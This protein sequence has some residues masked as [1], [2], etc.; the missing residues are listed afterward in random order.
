MNRPPGTAL[1]NI[2]VVQAE[3][4]FDPN[5]TF[6]LVAPVSNSLFYSVQGPRPNDPKV[7]FR[8]P[9][10]ANVIGGGSWVS[11][12]EVLTGM[13]SRLFGI[14][15][16]YTHVSLSALSRHTFP[17]YLRDRGYEDV[18]QCGL[19]HRRLQTE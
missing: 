8:G 13:D 16:R 1:P 6:T 11:E 7:H 3:S 4:T 18:R 14:A 10:L 15:G 12:F 2:I 17:R 9:A 5:D 19:T